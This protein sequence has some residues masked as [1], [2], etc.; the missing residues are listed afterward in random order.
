MLP[1]SGELSDKQT[2]ALQD[3]IPYQALIAS[4]VHKYVTGRLVDVDDDRP[5]DQ[6]RR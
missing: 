2:R 6:R 4:V 5:R 1:I 3:G